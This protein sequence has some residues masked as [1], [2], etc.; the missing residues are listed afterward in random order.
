VKLDYGDIDRAF[1]ERTL[2]RGYRYFK[3]GHVLSVAIAEENKAKALVHGS[4]EVPYIV[5]LSVDRDGTRPSLSGHCSCP[6]ERNCKHVVAAAFAIASGNREHGKPAAAEMRSEEGDGAVDVWIQELSACHELARF[7]DCLASREHLR[8]TIDLRPALFTPKLELRA[9]V[10]PILK[11]GTFGASRDYG[12]HNLTGGNHKAVIPVDRTIGRLAHA[13]GITEHTGYSLSL[14]L[15]GTLL[16]LI[17]GTGRA[18]WQSV[19]NPV[20]RNELITGSRIVWELGND[21]RQRPRLE[22]RPLSLLLP[23]VPLWY[24]DPERHVAGIAAVDAPP[25][26]VAMIAQSPALSAAQAE[27]AHV[28]LRHVFS[29]AGIEPPA[30][31]VDVRTMDADPVPVV[32]LFVLPATRAGG[33]AAAPCP[34]A[35]LLFQYGEQCVV[36]GDAQREFRTSE[37]EIVTVWPRRFAFEQLAAK[38]L[39]ECGF[40]PVGWPYRIERERSIYYSAYD[41]EHRW[42]RFLTAQAPQLEADGWRIEIGADFPY[43]ILEPDEDSWHAEVIEEDRPQWFELELGIDVEGERIS[44]LPVLLDALAREGHTIATDP[45]LIEKRSAPLLGK[46]PGGKYVALAPE[47]V[48][49]VLATVGALFGESDEPARNGRISVAAVRAAALADDGG[50]PLRWS[51]ARSLRATIDQLASFAQ[52]SVKL[53]KTFKAQLRPYQRDGVAWLQTLRE[54]DFGG[55]LA[56]DMG[57]GKTVQLLAHVAVERAAKRLDAPVLVVAPTSVAPNWRAEIARFLPSARVVSLTGPDRAERFDAI[58]GAQIALTTY[59][60]LPRDIDTLEQHEWSV[61]VL[62]EAQAIKNPKAKAALAAARLR[63]RQRIALTGTP[64]E[65][66]LEELWSIYDFAVPGLLSD[67]TR[68]SRIFRTPIEKRG[69]TLRRAALAARIKPFL[70]R[71]TKEQVA[72]ELPEKTEIVQHIEL[73][74]AQRDLYETIR[75]AMHQRVR[76]EVARRGL[77]RSGIVVLDALLKLRQVCCDPRLLKIAAAQ[78]VRESQKLD[79]LLEMLESL[80][81]DGRR[82]LLFSQFTSMLDLIKPELTER[83]LAFVELR[84]ET[85]DRETPVARFQRGE[86]PLFLISLKAG[87]TGLNLTAADTVIHYDPWWN[88]AVERQ[89]TD[90]AHRIG[91]TQHVFVY[92]LITE[93]TVEERILELQQRKGA[94]AAGLLDDAATEKLDLD[95]DDIDRLFS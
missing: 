2:E 43:T 54:H 57:L 20:L 6:M 84:G 25:E 16:D 53:P 35:E 23:S 52:R 80:V 33:Y 34:A 41:D 45:R 40:S 69:D 10:V 58:A 32:R 44:L 59:A 71:R 73:N 65:N 18:H 13:A 11:N 47:R 68:F 82:V 26:I 28:A 86:V 50:I 1:D 7:H 5:L 46:L 9:L 39:P 37:G 89:A 67:R 51:Q 17:V 93:G 62:D 83:H 3:T 36:P 49:R 77:A 64:I 74:G 60:L 91:Q 38:R 29:S 30:A 8:Y 24:V 14:T 48:A 15:V 94:L 21:G 31:S 76:D 87:G 95:L 56:D 70:L 27:R 75:L 4:R 85:R 12:L 66:H 55:V 90:R 78:S 72:R 81:E 79:A 42:L 61:L 22:N 63:A 92:K 88:P 19:K